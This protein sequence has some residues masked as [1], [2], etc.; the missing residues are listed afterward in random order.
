MS[1]KNSGL[2]KSNPNLCALVDGSY[3]GSQEIGTGIPK[4]LD[5]NLKSECLW[6]KELVYRSKSIKY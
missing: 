4:T 2:S 1:K 5:E 6:D 3:G